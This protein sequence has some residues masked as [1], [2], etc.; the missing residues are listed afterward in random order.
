[1]VERVHAGE[2]GGSQTSDWVSLRFGTHELGT[3]G[4]R[5]LR[6]ADMMRLRRLGAL[7]LLV[8]LL[9]IPHPA[10]G[11]GGVLSTCE[12]LVVLRP[13]GADTHSTGFPRRACYRPYVPLRVQPGCVS[14]C[15][16]LIRTRSSSSGLITHW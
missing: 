1:L 4:A 16:M 15:L 11:R 7:A 9:V 12:S 2:S 13:K 10:R 6:P 5:G 14:D 8:A 3:P